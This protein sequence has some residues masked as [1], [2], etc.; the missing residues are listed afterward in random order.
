MKNIIIAMALGAAAGLVL[1][2]IPAV[3]NFMEKGKKEVKKMVK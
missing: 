2:E 1:S 3:K